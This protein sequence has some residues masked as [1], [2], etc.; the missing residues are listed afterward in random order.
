MKNRKIATPI[1]FSKV[2]ST[3]KEA[4]KD[5]YSAKINGSW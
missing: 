5:K 2:A 4:K 3:Q 1:A